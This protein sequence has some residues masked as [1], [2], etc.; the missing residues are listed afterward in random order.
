[1]DMEA[2]AAKLIQMLHSILSNDA[3]CIKTNQEIS[4]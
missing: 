4:M 1:M 2:V 3:I